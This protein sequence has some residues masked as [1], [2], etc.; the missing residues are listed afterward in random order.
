MPVGTIMS[1]LSYSNFTEPTDANSTEPDGTRLM[2][3]IVNVAFAY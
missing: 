2:K 3:H 1:V